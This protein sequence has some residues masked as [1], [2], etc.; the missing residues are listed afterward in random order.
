MRIYV[1]SSAL[2]KR[3]FAEPES[4]KLIQTLQDE[5]RRD[6]V[7]LTSSLSWVEVSR[8]VLSTAVQ[9]DG[10]D[11]DEVTEI[12]LSG[13]REKP[14]NPDVIGVARRLAPR[15]LRSLDAIHLASA[16]MLNATV[17]VAY[18]TRLIAAAQMNNLRTRSPAA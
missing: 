4:A 13:L 15:T 17:M 3:V 11:P 1:D 6:S 10:L 8:A 16:L 5:L 7:L 18:D 9:S 12:A 2:L 14:I